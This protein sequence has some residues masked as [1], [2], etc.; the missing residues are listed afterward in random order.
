MG[1]F[2]CVGLIGRLASI[3]TQYSLQRLLAYLDKQKVAVL[4]DEE[5]ASVLPDTDLPV[6]PQK[7]AI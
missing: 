6:K 4:I 1:H 7:N 3:S 2:K 5:T